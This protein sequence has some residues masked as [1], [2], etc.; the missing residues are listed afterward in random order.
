M[1]RIS[2]LLGV[3]AQMC[4]SMIALAQK[5]SDE[6]P[7][8]EVAALKRSPSPT[9]PYALSQ[10]GTRVR[11]T[12]A[13][14]L[15]L[16]QNAYEIDAYQLK[17]PS[18]LLYEHYEVEAIMPEGSTKEQVPAMLRRLLEE[19]L[20]LSAHREVKETA[21]YVLALRG[22][23][24][25]AKPSDPNAPPTREPFDVSTEKRSIGRAFLRKLPDD[26]E[27]SGTAVDW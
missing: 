12:G 14:L 22:G 25:K 4:C 3:L 18:W 2:I 10:T 13:P 24:I 9:P 16:V 7:G 8:F 27:G 19:R 23:G 11:Y 17:G 15:F 5:A 20:G 21:A 6:P 1:A 26:A